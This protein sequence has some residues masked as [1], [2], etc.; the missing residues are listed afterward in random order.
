V[1]RDDGVRILLL[2]LVV[3]A[4][5][6]S[7]QFVLPTYHYVNM[8]R[9]MLFAT[10]T[11]G[12]NIL[13]GYTGLM[14]LGHAMFFAAGLYGAGLPV[15]YLGLG[16]P[17]GFA[18]GIF[19]GLSLAIAIGAIALRA[20]GIAFLIV[21]L[22]FAQAGFLATLYFNGIT[23]GDQGL[24]LSSKLAPLNIFGQE[25]AL[26]D[27]RV[28]Y[29]V[30][31]LI[32]FSCLLA[33]VAL[34]RS[35]IGRVLIAIRENEARTA[36]LGYNPYLYKLLAVVISG[37]MAAIAGAAYAILF[38]YIG[39]TFASIQYSILPLLWALLG[40]VGTTIGPIVG[41]TLMFYLVELSSGVTSAYLLIVG[42]ALVMITLWFPSGIVGWI[43]DRWLAWLP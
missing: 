36:M 16:A 25:L 43:R 19:A 35:P 5:L 3:L 27:L 4:G 22:M 34:V 39:S 14:S 17:L 30:A 7:A 2:H 32:F 37:T 18:A 12:Y 8:A 9:I 13:L 40:G 29:N 15:Y 23:L 31:F 10:F 1:K 21:T 41:T 42:V 33:T 20:S 28:K 6:F 11:M 24:V 26:S 38:S